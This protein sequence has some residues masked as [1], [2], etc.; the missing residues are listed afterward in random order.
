V[1]LLGVVLV[2]ATGMSL[3]GQ[4][5]LDRARQR[6]AEAETAQQSRVRPIE[7]VVRPRVTFPG[8]AAGAR[9]VARGEWD[10]GRQLLVAG[11]DLGGRSGFWVLTPL[12]L[13]DGSG[14]GVVRGWVPAADDAAA[15]APAGPVTVTGRLE[16]A[17]PAAPRAPGE[18]T[19][20]PAGQLRRVA[21][22]DLIA[23]W[24]YPLVT[25]YVIAE[26]QAPP[27]AAP[28]PVPVPAE[29][30]E[31]GLAW[32][33]LSY[34]VQWWAFA[35]FGLFFW[36]RLVRDDHAGRLRGGGRPGGA[37]DD[38]DDDHD[39]DDDDDDDDPG[40]PA[41]S[42]VGNDAGATEAA[43]PPA[44]TSTRAPAPTTAPAPAQTAPSPGARP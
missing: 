29:A 23:A 24:P 31:T 43:R 35:L 8:D 17:E 12:R 19:G 6:G 42:P 25:G 22:T 16:P 15:A 4:W 21:A 27:A 20:L 44:R 39:D 36:W 32:Q 11:R 18:G 40:A 33:N 7:D 3:L 28:A 13:A 38:H 30:P 26:S 37:D 14:V 5:Q 2:A 1:V 9:V 34:A 10:G 41:P